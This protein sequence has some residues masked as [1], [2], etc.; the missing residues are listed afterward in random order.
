MIVPWTT[1]PVQLERGSG[2]RLSLLFKTGADGAN[3]RTW[4]QDQRYRVCLTAGKLNYDRTQPSPL[5]IP[6]DTLSWDVWDN[7]VTSHEKLQ[8]PISQLYDP[9]AS[10]S[11]GFISEDGC[12]HS[13]TTVAHGQSLPDRPVPLDERIRE[14]SAEVTTGQTTE[15]DKA[16]AIYDWVLANMKYDKSG[17]GWGN[18]D[19]H[20]ACD[21]KRGNCTDFHALFIGWA[22]AANIPAK[23]EI[24]LPVPADKPSGG[25][26]GYHCWAEF[27]LNGYGWVPVDASEAWKDPSK[28]QYFFDAHDANPVQFSIHTHS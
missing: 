23:F 27:Y 1:F 2:S 15:L 5:T 4:L 14:L 10:A 20:W 21:A 25:I 19:I 24:A 8:I 17:K 13:L 18:G 9:A 3:P 22:R 7:A 11:D 12:V 16:R 26:G 6:L 28:R